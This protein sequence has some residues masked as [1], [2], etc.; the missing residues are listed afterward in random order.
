M[1]RSAESAIFWRERGVRF[2]T[3]SMEGLIVAGMK[4][5]LSAVKG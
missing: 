4:G 2:I 5:Y 3:T 1:V